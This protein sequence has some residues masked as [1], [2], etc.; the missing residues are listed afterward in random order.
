M[1][2]Q[3]LLGR[4]ALVTGAASGIGRASA[5]TMARHGANVIAV[6]KDGEG[7]EQLQAYIESQYGHCIPLKADITD[8]PSVEAAVQEGVLQFGSKLD[9]V[10]A[11]AGINGTLSPIESMPLEEWSRT[12]DVNLKGSF[13]TL[14]H[15]IPFLKIRGG[16]V[17]ITSS[18]NGNRIFSNF[19]FST[20]STT[21]AGQVAFAKMAAL[22]LAQ[23]HIRVNVICPGA[24]ETNIG[25]STEEKPEV[26]DIRIPVEYPDGSQPLRKGPGSPR[27]V[28]NLVL[29]LA[30]S[31]SCHITGTEIYI[32]GA[33]SLI[34]G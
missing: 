9:V 18:V 33:E 21:K 28:A 19:G 12:V 5:M 16:S 34:R 6:D 29:F 30:S 31:E 8:E 27:E 13:L 3:R 25:D 32:D 11:N 17:I 15:T 22:E 26:E 1:F 20:Y 14:K 4:T 10:F 2:E 24:I 23:Y 7:L